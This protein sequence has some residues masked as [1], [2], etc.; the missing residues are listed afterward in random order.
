MTYFFSILPSPKATNRPTD[1][2]LASNLDHYGLEGLSPWNP[3]NIVGL[4][5]IQGVK[6]DLLDPSDELKKSANNN[7][8]ATFNQIDVIS[9]L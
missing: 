5:P 7:N 8:M 4:D 3:T 1:N 6:W 9:N 2:Y